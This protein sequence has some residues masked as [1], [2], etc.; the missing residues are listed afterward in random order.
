MDSYQ[1]KQLR[2]TQDIEESFKSGKNISQVVESVP[3]F[4]SDKRICLTSVTYLPKE[5]EDKIINEVINPLNQIDP[6]QYYYVP[7][8]L[9]VTINN[10]R[11]INDPP[12]FNDQD[13]E[14]AKEVFARVIPKFKTFKVD[15]KRLFELP[16]SLAISV[17]SDE[18]LGSLALELRSELSK[19]G[20]ADDKIYASGDVVIG[21]TTIS[22]F[23][24]APN[25]DFWEKVREL[26]E[27]EIGSFEIKKV[28]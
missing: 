16:T 6:R 19:A 20:V 7:K 28:S 11:V 3:D 25:P 15:I 10:I 17:F 22:R 13:I 27:I 18:T 23:T 24:T 8:S 26:K 4:V 14:K 9:H 1:Q 5:L 21:N 2:L 12:H